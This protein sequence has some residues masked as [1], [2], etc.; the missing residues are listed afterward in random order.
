MQTKNRIRSL[1]V[2][3]RRLDPGEAELGIRVEPERLTS[4]TEVKGRLVGP[5]CRYASTVE[6]A[7]PFREMGRAY[8]SEDIP[9]LSMRVVIPE[10]SFWEPESP[11]LYSGPVEL[12]QSGSCCDSREIRHGLRFLNLG[13][14]GL[15]WNGR[16]LTIQGVECD[17]LSEVEASRLHELGCNAL[18]VPVRED[19]ADL[20]T[21]A[22][23][24]GFLML[25]LLTERKEVANAFTLRAHPS[26]LGWVIS[27]ELLQDD[28]MQAALPF[29]AQRDQLIGAEVTRQ[30]G[31]PLPEQI[32]FI[33]CEE[34]LLPQLEAIDLPKL[35][36]RRSGFSRETLASTLPTGILG[37]IF[38]RV[39]DE[40]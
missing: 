27:D 1:H 35:I 2:Y 3:A 4:A 15:R 14:R 16:L 26:C 28:V 37:R 9:H 38:E 18:L 22:D 39:R 25:G 29:P 6:V 8:E 13:S 19:A 32:Q 31:N 10:A 36:L 17:R 12:W 7:Y 20:W 23:Q 40:G 11:F 21:L 5:Q 33:V 24:T 34:S 30:P